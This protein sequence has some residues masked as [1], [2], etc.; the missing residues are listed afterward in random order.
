MANPF[1]LK[2]CS[3][4]QTIGDGLNFVTCEQTL[5][6]VVEIERM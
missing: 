4:V 2:F 1:I 6:R 5:I 3:I